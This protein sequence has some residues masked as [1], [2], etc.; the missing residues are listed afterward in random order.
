MTGGSQG[1]PQDAKGSPGHS[2]KIAREKMPKLAMPVLKSRDKHAGHTHG[3]QSV[4]GSAPNARRPFRSGDGQAFMIS[5]EFDQPS[6]ARSA[7]MLGIG[8]LGATKPNSGAHTERLAERDWRKPGLGKEDSL[9]VPFSRGSTGSHSIVAMERVRTVPRLSE[10]NNAEIARLSGT[11]LQKTA[12]LDNWP[13]TNSA[14]SNSWLRRLEHF[15]ETRLAQ[16]TDKEARLLAFHECFAQFSELFKL[17]RPLLSRI[18]MAYDEYI[19]DGQT[20]SLKVSQAQAELFALQEHAQQ[21][22]R[23]SAICV[24]EQLADMKAAVANA[25]KERDQAVKELAAVKAELEGERKEVAEERAGNAAIREQARAFCS[26]Y[27]WIIKNVLKQEEPHDM[28]AL[29]NVTLIQKLEKTTAQND[30]QQKQLDYYAS[31]AEIVYVQNVLQEERKAYLADTERLS[32]EFSQ[33]Q[34]VEAECRK[35]L[36]KWQ[37]RCKA[38]EANIQAVNDRL[39]KTYLPPLGDNERL[40]V[41]LRTEHPLVSRDVE[42]EEITDLLQT[43]MKRSIEAYDSG[44]YPDL[45]SIFIDA[46]REKWEKHTVAE[47][48]RNVLQAIDN[49]PLDADCQLLG[50]MLATTM[51]THMLIHR[52]KVNSECAA[53]LTWLSKHLMEREGKGHE[54]QDFVS[55]KDLSN[56]IRLAFPNKTEAQWQA[57][58]GLLSNVTFAG[59][60]IDIHAIARGEP[61]DVAVIIFS[62]C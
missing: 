4:P 34:N 59:H 45:E 9:D 46:V 21:E 16:A 7:G 6:T 22:V 48:G 44:T 51:G 26:G 52:D 19:A 37:E 29:E 23:K 40:P 61:A 30:S 12:E 10:F 17:Y 3:V 58:V 56:D 62:S 18:H 33:L 42:K 32:S 2:T 13:S 20:A 8:G 60:D 35:D 43:C 53:A 49:F 55:A 36:E 25:E 54:R 50:S 31:T 14:S 27:R 39:D 57:L 41:F 15:L 38:L 28:D 1:L 24:T 47:W 5:G 11:S